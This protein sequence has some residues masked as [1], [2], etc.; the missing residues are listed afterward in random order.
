MK[1]RKGFTLIDLLIS[2]SILFITT[3]FA[4]P[5]LLGYLEKSRV[6]ALNSNIVRLLNTAR[7]TAINHS[8]TVTICG[9]D[10]NNSCSS[11]SFSRVAIFFDKNDDKAVSDDGLEL[12]TELELK[13]LGELKLQASFGREYLRFKYNGS[14]Q[15]AGSFIYCNAKH[16]HLNSRVTTSLTGRTYLARRRNEEGMILAANTTDAICS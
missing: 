16:P 5:N 13:S 11:T 6:R 9:L 14:S 8:R 3:G 4:L 10:N 15:Q 2:L 1:K 12:I 7:A